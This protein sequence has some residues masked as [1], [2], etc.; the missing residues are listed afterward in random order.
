[1][2]KNTWF[3]AALVV[4]IIS[5][6][7]GSAVSD[8]QLFNFLAAPEKTEQIEVSDSPWTRT[9][10]TL[11]TQLSYES[12]AGAETNTVTMT[13]DENDVVTAFE[14]SIDTKNE[15]SVRYQSNFVAQIETEIVGKKISELSNLD[16]VGGA[17]TTTNAFTQAIKML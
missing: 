11:T 3:V 4:I 10:N 2:S 7:V 5:Y 17:S 14:I 9:D 6:F 13:V 12:P 15:T 1:M 8:A 16:A